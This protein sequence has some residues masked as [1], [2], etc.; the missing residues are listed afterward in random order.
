MVRNHLQVTV[1]KA[2]LIHEQNAENIKANRFGFMK[3]R[4]W[5]I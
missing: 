1:L 4:K 2:F 3:H 5:D